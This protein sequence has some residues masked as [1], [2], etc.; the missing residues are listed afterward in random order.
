MTTE[1]KTRQRPAALTLTP[2]AEQRIACAHRNHARVAVARGTGLQR[3]SA[4]NADLARVGGRN[5]D[6]FVLYRAIS[7]RDPEAMAANLKGYRDEGYR[8]FQLKVGRCGWP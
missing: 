3:N 7:K 5:G 8:R 6:D 2:A 4:A 1:T